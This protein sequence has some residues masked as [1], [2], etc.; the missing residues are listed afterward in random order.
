MATKRNTRKPE[1]TEQ[2]SE[3]I[4]RAA[5]ATEVEEDAVTAAESDSEDEDTESESEGTEERTSEELPMLLDDM[6]AGEAEE[7]E[8]AHAP[9]DALGLYLR[10]MGAIPLLSR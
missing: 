10:Q 2:A 3:T 4:V 9:D 5:R 7:G 1:R 6:P 8:D